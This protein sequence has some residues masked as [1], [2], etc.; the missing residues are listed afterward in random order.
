MSRLKMFLPRWQGGSG[1]EV[2]CW[3]LV[4]SSLS[5]AHLGHFDWKQR[6]GTERGILD[7]KVMRGCPL[8]HSSIWP[9]HPL[10]EELN[11]QAFL[12]KSK[13]NHS[14]CGIICTQKAIAKLVFFL[15]RTYPPWCFIL[16]FPPGTVIFTD[17]FIYLFIYLSIYLFIYLFIYISAYV[18]FIFYFIYSY[19]CIYFF[20]HFLFVFNHLYF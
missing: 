9:R 2:I 14:L 1:K 16:G 20:V 11:Q 13:L 4:A 3:L 19:S 6:I 12:F 10:G 15:N 7:T 18:Y 8:W 17:L 5:E